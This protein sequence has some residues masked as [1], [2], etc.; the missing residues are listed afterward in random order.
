MAM[1]NR[2][3]AAHDMTH[4]FPA[5]SFGLT[6]RPPQRTTAQAHRP[7]D[8][9]TP[10][11]PGRLLYHQAATEPPRNGQAGLTRTAA[12]GRQVGVIQSPN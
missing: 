1:A 9:D 3:Q 2:R 7:R 8:G 11:V 12:R 10:P 4:G 5:L 6:T